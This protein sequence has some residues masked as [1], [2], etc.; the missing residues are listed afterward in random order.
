MKR[1]NKQVEVI[2]EEGVSNS[3]TQRDELNVIYF[4]D[5]RHS[6]PSPPIMYMGVSSTA[7]IKIF[8]K[9]DQNADL[10]ISYY[11]V[12]EEIYQKLKNYKKH[13]S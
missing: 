7:H 1:T 9:V 4:S 6:L 12:D 10:L 5:L 11:Y 2:I 13:N 3:Y 8:T